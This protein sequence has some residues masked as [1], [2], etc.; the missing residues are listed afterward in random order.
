MAPVVGHATRSRARSGYATRHGL[1]RRARY[2][3]GLGRDTR[4]TSA[5]CVL[6]GLEAGSVRLAKAQLQSSAGWS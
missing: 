4:P 5:G 2:G 6:A 1:G 3:G